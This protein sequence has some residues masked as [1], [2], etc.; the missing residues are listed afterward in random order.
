MPLIRIATRRSPLARWQADFVA[1][2]L[3]ALH[4]Q[5]EIDILPMQTK[6]DEWLQSSLSKIGG[7]GLFVKELELALLA[8]DADIAVHSMKDV[9]GSFPDGLGLPVIMER[10]D[11]RDALLGVKAVSDLALGACVGTAS[12]RRQLQ[13]VN[14]RPDLKIKLLRGNIQTRMQK[15]DDGHYDA[16]LLAASG[17]KRMQYEH[18]IDHTLEPEEMLPAIGQGALGIECR[19]EDKTTRELIQGLQHDISAIRVRAERAVGQCMG[20]SCQ[21]P[22]AA[23][24]EIDGET[25]HLRALMGDPN[26]GETLRDE[27]RAPLDQAEAL[28]QQLGENLLAAGGHAILQRLVAST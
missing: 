27:G 5:L 13:L 2:R 24:A 22:V 21:T 8:G 17:L 19:L 12:Q 4:P 7:K 16:I 26:N 20:S 10:H 28:G 15:L 9:P 6:G 25:I 11:P 3:R 1:E 14:Q 23:Y 18:R